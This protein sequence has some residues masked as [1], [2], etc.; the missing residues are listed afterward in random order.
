MEGKKSPDV[1]IRKWLKC[2]ECRWTSFRYRSRSKDY[3]C[4][5][6]GTIF[7]ADYDKGYTRIT[8][9]S[10]FTLKKRR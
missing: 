6:C 9:P 7:I 10:M 1:P 4:M 3:L 5:H 2:P 8:Q